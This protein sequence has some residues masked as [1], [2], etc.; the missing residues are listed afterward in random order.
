MRQFSSLAYPLPQRL[1]FLFCVSW[2]KVGRLQCIYNGGLLIL[3]YYKYLML[4]SLTGL[5]NISLRVAICINNDFPAPL[6][7]MTTTIL[8]FSINSRALCCQPK[9]DKVITR[10]LILFPVNRRCFRL[11]MF[12]VFSVRHSFAEIFFFTS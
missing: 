2:A 8:W 7:A 4:L 12:E 3:S 6:P 5:R 9:G 10:L 1:M 11:F